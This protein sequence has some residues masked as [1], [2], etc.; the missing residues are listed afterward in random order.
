LLLTELYL[1]IDPSGL[2]FLLKIHLQPIGFAP[3]GRSVKIH[4]LFFIIESI[5]IFI[6]S[7]QNL[8]SKEDSAL[9]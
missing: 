6:A 8:A 3:G 9:E 5:S 4:V 2:S 1:Y 7:F